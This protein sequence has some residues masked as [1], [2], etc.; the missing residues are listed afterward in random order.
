MSPRNTLHPLELLQTAIDLYRISPA[1]TALVVVTPLALAAT[2]LF[3]AVRT[4]ASLLASLAFAA[5]MVGFVVVATGYLEAS[6][7]RRRL[8]SHVHYR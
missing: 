7:R 5:A 1:E 4:D 3:T 6:Y 8:E 2:Q